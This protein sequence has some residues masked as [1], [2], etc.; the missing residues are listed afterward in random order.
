MIQF[1]FLKNE[2]LWT[3]GGGENAD[4][5][6]LEVIFTVN[7]LGKGRLGGMEQGHIGGKIAEQTEAL[8]LGR[9][10]LR[11]SISFLRIC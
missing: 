8:A 1:W 5:Y 9:I 4:Q 10:P 7:F 3:D 6:L 11:R 2:L